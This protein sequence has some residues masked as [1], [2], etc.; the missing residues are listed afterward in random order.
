MRKH[1]LFMIGLAT[2]V[3]GCGPSSSQ[4]QNAPTTTSGPARSD[5]VAELKA[6]ASRSQCAA[7][8]WTA[9]GRAP[10]SYIEGVTL[11]FAR[12][13]CQPK[14]VDVQVVSAPVDLSSH[15]DDALAIYQSAF[16][17]NGMRND[18]AGSTH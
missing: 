7:H 8:D 1:Q 17:A 12:A 11:V 16:Q 3:A 2:A 4:A 10:L 14:R 5:G 9:R 15:S 13:V 18:T 6:I